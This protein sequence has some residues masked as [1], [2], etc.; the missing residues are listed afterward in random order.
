MLGGCCVTAGGRPI[1]VVVLDAPGA[2]PLPGRALTATFVEVHGPA[3]V[4]A[5]IDGE[6]VDLSTRSAWEIPPLRCA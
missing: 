5:G 6:A 1:G 3:P 2:G 4:H